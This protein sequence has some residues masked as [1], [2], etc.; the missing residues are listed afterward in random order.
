L[1]AKIFGSENPKSYVHERAGLGPEH[2]YLL[3]PVTKRLGEP[4][5]RSLFEIGFG[6]GA[7][8][9]YFSEAGFRVTGIEP[10]SDGVNLA[11]CHYPKLTALHE[12]NVYDDLPGLYGTFDVVLSLEVVEHLY[13]PKV[14]AANA[15]KLL[16]KGGI[17][18]ISTP[19]NGWL[20]NVAIAVLAQFDHH[21]TALW[22]HGHIKFWSIATMTRLLAD[23]GF[24]GIEFLRVGRIPP[25]AKSMI[26][27][28][29]K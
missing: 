25:L 28:A 1:A 26:A 2:A 21:H 19:Y 14:F 13:S 11:K 5:G 29:K 12:G 16:N 17:A 4:R 27:I 23:A 15:F 24:E 3:P 9:N 7:V 22:D 8:A 18:I 20:K 10:S 6:N